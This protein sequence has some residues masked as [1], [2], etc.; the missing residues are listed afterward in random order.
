[1]NTITKPEAEIINVAKRWPFSPKRLPLIKGAFYRNG[2]TEIINILC[3]SSSMWCLDQSESSILKGGL[4]IRGRPTIIVKAGVD[5]LLAAII[6]ITMARPCWIS[7]S[8]SF[9][10]VR[11][12]FISACLIFPFL[13][14]ALVS[15][16]CDRKTYVAIVFIGQLLLFFFWHER[17]FRKR[18]S[19]KLKWPLNS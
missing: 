18:V 9:S 12:T 5:H 14:R 13:A 1:M 3:F 19:G 6:N 4:L 15:E 7:L 8:Y 16:T 17:W 10:R 2:S 11:G